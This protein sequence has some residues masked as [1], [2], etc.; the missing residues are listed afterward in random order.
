MK[1]YRI[2]YEPDKEILS[3]LNVTESLYVYKYTETS[4]KNQI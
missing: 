2:N 3:V 4:L 1:Y